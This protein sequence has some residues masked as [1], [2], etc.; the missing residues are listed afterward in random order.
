MYYFKKIGIGGD[1]AGFE[2]KE[3]IKK[4]LIDNGFEV[5]DF[6]TYNN[7]RTDYPDYGHP[8][9]DAVEKGEYETG[10]AVCGSGNGINMTVN[11]HKGIRGA[12]CWNVEIA[13]L[14]R[15]H[16]DANICSLPGRFVTSGEAIDIVDKFLS[17][18]FDGGRH[19]I[20][21]DKIPGC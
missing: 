14:A 13:G 21:T 10:I 8:L 6:G 9:A 11:K 5:K 16:N 17:T 4:Y 20:R 19:K 15:A 12:L 2:R 3:Q 1:H 18:P 7:K